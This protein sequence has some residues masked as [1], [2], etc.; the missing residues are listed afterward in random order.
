LPVLFAV[1]VNLH[2]GFM[3]GLGIVALW[4]AGELWRARSNP[5][6]RAGL[7]SLSVAAVLSV[8]ATLL[9]PNT[10]EG[11]SYPLRY[12]GSGLSQSLQEERPGALDSGYAWVHFALL[13]AL[14]LALATRLRQAAPQ[15]VGLGVFLAW[16]SMP[17]MGG[18]AL[19]FAAERHA[20]LLLL[21]GTPLLVWQLS[22]L[23]PRYAAFES[24]AARRLRSPLAWGAGALVVVLCLAWALRALPRQHGADEPVLPGRFPS[25]AARWLQEN[26]LPGNLINPY[27]WG[28]HLAFHLYPDYRVWID[29]RGDLYGIDRIREFEILYRMPPG[30]ERHVPALLD[31]YDANVIV[32]HLLTIDFGPLQVHPF[33]EWLLRSRE[34]RL[35]FYDRADPARPDH[36]SATTGVFLREHPRNTELLERY[37]PVRTPRLPRAPRRT[38]ADQGRR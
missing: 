11:A 7:R 20:P 25:A 1:W 37:K 17:R 38:P 14:L 30:A 36:P 32:W 23:S 12:I 33:A 24:A 27:R 6:A 10:F 22:A 35:V 13:V 28:G 19:P 4:A 5:S 26:R 9:N 15:H 21:L 34:W 18:G 8:A 3:F 29:S 16:I 2:G 31:R